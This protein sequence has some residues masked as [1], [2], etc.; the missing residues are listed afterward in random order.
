MS[1]SRVI[2]HVPELA[3]A[4]TQA[5]TG[6]LPWL[7]KFFS[8]AA[9]R[10]VEDG[11]AV[12]AECFGVPPDLLA[13]A[14]LERLAD[15]GQRDEACWWRADPVHLEADRDQLV[16]L[17]QA[18]LAVTADEGRQF[19]ETF[20]QSYAVDGFK[21]E[22]TQLER[23]YLRVSAAWHCR[24]WNPAYVEGKAVL[25]FMPAGKDENPVR[26]LM[27]EIQMLLHEHPV[28]QARESAGMPAINSLWLWAGGRLPQSVPQAPARIITTQPRVRGL[29]L[30][31]GRESESWPVTAFEQFAEGESLLALGMS[32]FDADM[33]RL[34]KQL[35]V[36]LWRALASGRVGEIRCYPGGSRLFILLR[37]STWRFWRRS[38]PLAE[39]LGEP[40]DSAPY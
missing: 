38:R 13:V 27:T 33:G 14:P 34:E 5:G 10:S 31:A 35:I 24:T 11:T 7:E 20:N 40:H 17:P 8:R 15:T 6:R 21:L 2:L 1:H 9:A 39:V 3:A 37:N 29:A 28:N 25:E 36:P 30:L 26:K 16:M 23:W 18:A 12:L 4:L 22:T 32:D 19:A